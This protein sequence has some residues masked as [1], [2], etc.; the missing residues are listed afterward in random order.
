MD[1]TKNSTEVVAFLTKF[2]KLKEWSDGTP[3]GLSELAVS[4]ISVKDLCVEVQEAASIFQQDEP[5]SHEPVIAPVD[6]VFRTAWRDYEKRYEH[7]LQQ[8][9]FMDWIFAGPGLPLDAFRPGHRPNLS[10]TWNI[11]DRS[12]SYFAGNIDAAVDFAEFKADGL[13][14]EDYCN[15][16]QDGC[17]AYGRLAQNIGFDARGMFRRWALFPQV[18]VPRHVAQKHGSTEPVSLYTLL[19]QAHDAFVYGAPYAALALMRSILE[20]VLRDHYGAKEGK[21]HERIDQALRFGRQKNSLHRIRKLVNAVLHWDKELGDEEK[22]FLS[23]T[24]EEQET[25][26]VLLLFS[27]RKLI[28]EAPKYR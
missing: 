6:P 11:E 15:R 5:H 23:G 28:E 14:D 25:H 19:Q 4:D 18:L 26:M 10:E 1:T 9:G 3:E 27:L 2:N 21:L 24:V 22:K 17:A 7:F 13:D 20:K 8:I 16:I 12:A